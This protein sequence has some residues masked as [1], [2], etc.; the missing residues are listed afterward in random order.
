MGKLLLL[1]AGCNL[2]VTGGQPRAEAETVVEAEVPPDLGSEMAAIAGSYRADYRLAASAKAPP[3][4]FYLCY[5][6]TP[7]TD[8][9]F[10]AV[11]GQP[12]EEELRITVY[13][14]ELAWE[15]FQET[16]ERS[17]PLGAVI[18]KEKSDGGLGIM[19]KQAGGWV[20]GF[21]DAEGA[22]AVDQM[23]TGPCASCHEHGTVPKGV[24]EASPVGVAIGQPRDSVFLTATGLAGKPAPADPH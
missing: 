17:F 9:P 19:E 20:Y 10:H 6:P 21:V 16:G 13:V 12:S 4:F 11:E 14:N 1:L 7:G 18:V 8:V 22:V 2:S 23:A 5:M 24:S 15:P 3:G